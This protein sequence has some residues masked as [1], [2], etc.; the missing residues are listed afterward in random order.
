MTGRLNAARGPLHAALLGVAALCIA[1]PAAAGPADRLREG[2]FRHRGAESAGPPIARYVSEDGRVFTLDRTQ[3][4]P[5]LKFDDSPEVWVLDPSPAPRGDVIYKNDMGEPVLRATR[6]GGFTLFTEDRPKGE[7]VSVAGGASPLRLPAMGPQ[8]VF[9]R[10]A[11]ASIRATRAAH[12]TMSFEAEATPASS[13]LI[14]DA[15]V[16]ASVAIMRIA[17]TDGGAALLARFNRVRFEEGRKA[18]ASVKAG[19]MRIT[20]APADGLAGR[21]SSD[22][23]VRAAGGR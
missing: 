16:V 13:A 7:A 23:I 6:L 5:L 8:A 21:P 2:L 18:S 12:R 14:A 1:G 20:V 15:A 11:Q 22:R 9:A 3:P 17:E 19:V 10:L 4:A